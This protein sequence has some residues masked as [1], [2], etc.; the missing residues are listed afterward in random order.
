MGPVSAA[1]DTSHGPEARAARRA[2]WAVALGA[3]V[4]VCATLLVW[5]DL[6]GHALYSPD[7]GRYGSVSRTMLETGDWV[8]PVYRGHA[9]L[10]K[11]PLTY[12]LEAASMRALGKTELAL[13]A[14]SAL[15]TSLS[16]LI[17]L[18]CGWTLGGARRGVLAAGLY[19]IAPMVFGVGRLAT[20]DALLNLF[21]TGALTAGLLAVTTKHTRWVALLWTCAALG[22]L[23]KGP[24]ALTPVAA[25]LIWLSIGR[26]GRD[27]ARLWIPVGLPLS[28]VPLGL[29]V[30]AVWRLRPEAFTIWYGEIVSRAAG[31]GAH[32]EPIWF[33][34]PI[35]LAAM[36]PAAALLFTPGAWRL[37]RWRAGLVEA[38][39]AAL[40]AIAI[41]GP[42]VMF[43]LIR[44]KLPTYI[45]PTAAPTALLAAGFLDRA[46]TRARAPGLLIAM[47]IIMSVVTVGAVVMAARRAPDFLAYAGAL[48][49]VPIA[50]AI[51]WR[52]WSRTPVRASA[53]AVVF[54]AWLIVYGAG[55]RAEV[56]LRPRTDPRV[57]V[58][59]V[60]GVVEH[61]GVDWSRV[62][63]FA[64]YEP[65]V[66]F[67]SRREF[68]TITNADDINALLAEAPDKPLVLIADARTWDGWFRHE[69]PQTAAKFT[70][71]A[72]GARWV[73][74]T[75]L[76]LVST[77]GAASDAEGADHGE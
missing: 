74:R 71:A 55:A 24:V 44:G 11:P 67:Y 41:V 77:P 65:S 28:L 50:G 56:F 36:F 40:W 35:Y 70:I 21:W 45:L 13:R 16:V 58:D 5:L 42:I 73:H 37:R 62:R 4:V 7:E 15:A 6:G 47:T 29:W 72:T 60:R 52:M 1:E 18:G 64:F 66:A 2:P 10:T 59:L 61:E 22:L 48:A 69:A 46:L 26:R 43:S 32:N 53:L 49:L 27:L 75:V 25:L 51:A 54:A 17:V 9:H 12:W 20:T 8:L 76:V 23:T 68:A 33:F 63:Y 57:L 38:T 30:L 39:P 19:A 3:A 14:P 31:S 34:L